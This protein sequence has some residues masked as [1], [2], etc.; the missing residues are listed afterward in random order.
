MKYK[1]KILAQIFIF[2][3]LVS[4]TACQTHSP[5]EDKVDSVQGSVAVLVAEGF[6]DG[7]AYMPMGYLINNGYKITVIGPERGKVKAYNS[8]F[9][10]NIEKSVSEV[11][12]DDFDALILPGGRGPAV[13]REN[14]RVIE[15]VKSFWN[16]GKVTAAICHGP[17]VLVTADLLKDLV[18]TGTG[19]IKDEIEQAGA[20]YV[21]STVVVTGNLITSRNPQDLN[22]FSTSIVEALQK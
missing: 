5:A 11:S 13:L 3:L 18:L 7:E 17:Q 19:A 8:E 21:D 6:H 9:T 12:P 20:T 22:N 4:F 1:E 16:T 15:F 14:D 2:A 10:I